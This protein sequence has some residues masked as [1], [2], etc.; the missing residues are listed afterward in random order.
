MDPPPDVDQTVSFGAA[1]D[2]RWWDQVD[3]VKLIL[4]GN[5]LQKLSEDIIHLPALLILDVSLLVY[6]AVCIL[7]CDVILIIL[8]GL[9]GGWLAGRRHLSSPFECQLPPL[10]I[11][12][13]DLLY[14]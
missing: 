4:A 3:L 6:S 5:L 11:S 10:K 2:E 13:A 7:L 1:G 12:C 8:E 9:G 14:F